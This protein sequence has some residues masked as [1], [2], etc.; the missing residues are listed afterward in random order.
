MLYI[1]CFH[2]LA[3]SN[4]QSL[5]HINYLTMAESILNYSTEIIGAVEAKDI[6]IVHTK[7][8]RWILH[9]GKFQT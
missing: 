8:Y 2:F 6:E 5:K 3:K 7:L 4:D 1:T 9:V